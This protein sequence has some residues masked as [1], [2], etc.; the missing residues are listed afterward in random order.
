M[1][2]DRFLIAATLRMVIAQ[3]LVRRLCPFCRH[4]AIVSAEQARSLGRPRAE[5][6]TMFAAS[7]CV[8]CAGRGFSGRAGLFELLSMDEP[9][10]R[11]VVD[12]CDESRLSEIV[13]ERGVP[14]I[15]DDALEKISS[16]I[17]SI[18]EV[19]TAVAT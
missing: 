4:P 11:A 12:G 14:T 3:R 1:G 10:A 13:R 2:A 19:L 7:G 18:H 9:L 6:S 5:S 16:G 8:Y 17:T 15:L